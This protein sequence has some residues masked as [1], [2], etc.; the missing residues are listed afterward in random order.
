MHPENFVEIYRTHKHL[1]QFRVW[2]IVPSLD[3]QIG[4]SRIKFQ[5][6]RVDGKFLMNLGP[7]IN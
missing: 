2:L 3:P 4:D 5:V 6:L 1:N 7:I